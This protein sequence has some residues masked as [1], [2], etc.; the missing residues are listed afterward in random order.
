MNNNEPIK[1]KDNQKLK[2]VRQ[3]R[4]GRSANNIF[5]EGK[6]LAHEALRSDLKIE[7]CFVS[8]GISIDSDLEKKITTRKI[9]TVFVSENIFDSI[10]DT[11]NSQGIILIAAKPE[12]G[13]P[14]IENSPDQ[15][16]LVILLNEVNNPSNVGSIMR[17]AEAGGV[18]G[19]LITKNSV[20]PF[21]T[22]AIRASMGAAFRI[23]IWQGIDLKEALDWAK[24]NGLVSTAADI[25]AEKQY[26]EIDW[27]RPRLLVFGSEAEGLKDDELE[28]FDELITIQMKNE[29]ESLNLSVS[30]GIIIF[31]SLRQRS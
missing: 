18:A 31:E 29:T 2:Y 9:Q 23:P 19:I 6:R 8:T 15:R 7:Y 14:R 22:K 11:K 25:K 13:K 21:S 24:E 3:I 20:D 4:D 30:A 26:F 10:A 12:S 1:S 5:I 16:E 17:T 27:E 28:L